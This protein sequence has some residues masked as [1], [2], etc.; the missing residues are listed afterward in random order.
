MPSETRPQSVDVDRRTI[1]AGILGLIAADIAPR[2]M[3]LDGGPESRG[4]FGAWPDLVIEGEDPRLL[5]D[6]YERWRRRPD[7]VW[8]GWLSYDWGADRVLGR[9]LRSRRLPGI[10]LRRFPAAIELG[11]EGLRVHGNDA[12]AEQLIS[13]VRRVPPA[14]PP[15]W[16]FGPLRAGL[17][18]QAYRDKVE[19]A[20]RLIGEGETYQVNLAQPFAAPWRTTPS[21][22]AVVSAYAQLRSRSP[23]RM[24]ALFSIE[25]QWVLSNSP[26]TLLAVTPRPEGGSFAQSWPIKGTI[27]RQRDPLA[28]A[29]AQDALRASAKDAAEHVMIVDLVRNDLGMLARPGTVTA[30]STPEVVSL[31]HVHH[32]VTEV[33]AVVDAS[34][35]LRDWVSA[36]FPGGSITGAPK[37]RTVELIEQL[38]GDERGLYCGSILLLAPDGLRMSIAIRTACADPHGLIVFGGGGVVIDSD[39]EAERLETLAK[40][41]AFAGPLH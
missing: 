27:A 17:A 16:P 36:M 2:C 8:M 35:S 1:E 13:T 30:P 37:R 12:D 3:W 41:S 40:V 18:A 24:G 26:E 32:L 20:R 29:R 25:D 11:P 23:A 31:T 5:D 19:A 39:A 34:V 7:Q 9:P 10:G 15:A 4:W 6:A 33:N 21:P 14:G 28:D 22:E 38:E